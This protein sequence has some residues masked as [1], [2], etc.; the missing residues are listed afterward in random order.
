MSLS[1]FPTDDATLLAIEHAL[2]GLLAPGEDGDPVL[3]GADYS[4]SGLLDFLSGHAPTGDRRVTYGA[5]DVISALVSEVRRLRPNE[6]L[7]RD[8]R[9]NL[10]DPV[11]RLG[12]PVCKTTPGQ[13]CVCRAGNPAGCAR[14][15]ERGR[16]HAPAASHQYVGL[17][18]GWCL[19]TVEIDGRIDQCEL[20]RSAAVHAPTQEPS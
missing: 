10:A 14:E 17:R 5:H 7:E 1:P 15:R 2:G 11:G 8:I 20:P 13:H 12:W 16:A 4:L 9:A 19:Q 3:A 18:E 6:E